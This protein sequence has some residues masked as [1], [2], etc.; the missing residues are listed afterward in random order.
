MWW[1]SL[2][3][4]L[5]L[6][7]LSSQPLLHCYPLLV[8]WQ[9]WTCGHSRRARARVK[10]PGWWTT[11]TR[12]RS[13][14]QEG[15]C[16]FIYE[17]CICIPFVA[18]QSINF[19]LFNHNYSQL[20]K[21]YWSAR[22]HTHR[23]WPVLNLIDGWWLPEETC[24]RIRWIQSCKTAA[25]G[26]RNRPIPISSSCKIWRLDRGPWWPGNP[27]AQRASGRRPSAQWRKKGNYHK[28]RPW[29][30]VAWARKKISDGK[31]GLPGNLP[32]P[33]VYEKRISV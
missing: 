29:R 12:R 22:A 27:C 30:G 5:L 25:S 10:W 16:M 21:H 11:T 4:C 19:A 17:L 33:V 2:Y 13:P 32:L 6:D 8:E 9:I 18:S 31:S 3:R 15:N 20:I 1:G 24:R 23:G 26:D 14:E 28:C 7:Q